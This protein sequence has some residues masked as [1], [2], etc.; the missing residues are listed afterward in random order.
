VSSS[1]DSRLLKPGHLRSAGV[2]GGADAA[3]QEREGAD[4]RADVHRDGRRLRARHLGLPALRRDAGRVPPRVL[5]ELGAGNRALVPRGH[6]R[7]RRVAGAAHRPARAARRARQLELR[8]GQGE[9]VSPRAARA[10]DRDDGRAVLARPAAVLHLLRGDADSDVPAHRRLG[11]RRAADG[12]D[13]VLPLHAGRLAAHAGGAARRLLHRD[14]RRALTRST[15]RGVYNGL[16]GAA[17]EVSMCHGGATACS[18]GPAALGAAALRPVDVRRLRAGV[19]DQGAD[20]AAAHVAARTRT[21]RR[22]WRAR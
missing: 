8:A 21:R 14:F 20:V 18:P 7:H 5:D 16:L 13:E 9:G 3:A 22:R 12:G 2:R 1:Y 4:S 10:A 17:R 15:T 6:R 11:Q 19:R